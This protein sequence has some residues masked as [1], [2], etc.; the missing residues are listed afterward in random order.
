MYIKLLRKKIQKNKKLKISDLVE[1]IGIS[2]NSIF[3]IEAEKNFEKSTYIR[4]LF[5]L[6][7]NKIDINKLL[8]D[9]LKH[10]ET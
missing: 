8:D 2:K 4:Y 6:K 9:L 1:I 10:K 7:E 3:K 5:F